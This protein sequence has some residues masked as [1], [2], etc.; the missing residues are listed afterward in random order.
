[1]PGWSWPRSLTPGWALRSSQLQFSS[2]C[3]GGLL[4]LLGLAATHKLLFSWKAAAPP[5][6][7]LMSAWAP[8]CTPAP[9]SYTLFGPRKFRQKFYRRCGME[10]GQHRGLGGL[11]G[12]LPGFLNWDNDTPAQPYHKVKAAIPLNS[13]L[14]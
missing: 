4:S 3:H 12:S 5:Q 6:A 1:M 11:L 2:F 7:S 14:F 9:F 8:A 10:R 13:P